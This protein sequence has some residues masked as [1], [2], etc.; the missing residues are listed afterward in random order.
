MAVQFYTLTHWG[1]VT[2]L[3]VSKLTSIA[4]DNGL[5]PEGRQAIIWNNAWILLI[6]PLGTKFSEIL[7]KIHTFSLKKIRLKMST[8]CRPFCLGLNELK[9]PWRCCAAYLE[10]L[11]VFTGVWTHSCRNEQLMA[12]G[13]LKETRDGKENTGMSST[14]VKSISFSTLSSG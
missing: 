9:H 5:S 6:G 14:S 4:S 3:C 10:L 13:S 12:G 8:K 11:A 2:H 1:R 7:I